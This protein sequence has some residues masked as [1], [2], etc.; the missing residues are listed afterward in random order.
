[1]EDA[2]NKYRFNRNIER[3]LGSLAGIEKMF[4]MHSVIVYEKNTNYYLRKQVMRVGDAVPQ[5][6]SERVE[7]TTSNWTNL[8]I[9]LQEHIIQRSES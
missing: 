8:N 2:L 6:T 4:G 1:M 5:F 3:Y 7:I 9:L